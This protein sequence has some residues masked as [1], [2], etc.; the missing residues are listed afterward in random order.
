MQC[1]KCDERGAVRITEMFG[2]KPVDRFF[3]MPH[4]KREL[5][6]QISPEWEAL[7]DWIAAQFKQHGALPSAAQIAQHG[8]AGTRL[9]E[10]MEDCPEDSYLLINDAVRGRLV[11]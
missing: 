2:G 10:L 4:A 8:G 11:T 6:V 7:L 5:G 3:C 1:E 9:A